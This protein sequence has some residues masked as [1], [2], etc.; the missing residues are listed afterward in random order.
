MGS[1]STRSSRR[2]ASAAT[3]ATFWRLPFE[4]VRVFF[5]GS[6]SNRSSSSSRR[7]GS[8]PPPRRPSRS[9]T[10]PP[11]RLGHRPTSPGTYASRRC[12]S[13]ASAHGSPPKRPT[14]PDVARSRPSSTRM[15][16]DLPEPLGPR[17]PCTS[18]RSTVRSRPSSAR[19]DP[20]V[21][22]SPSIEITRPAMTPRSSAQSSIGLRS[23]IGHQSSTVPSIASRTRSA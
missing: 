13:T 21:L 4:Y 23:S 12:N 22:T 9:I 16:V 8:W 17:N 3:S 11:D 6:S 1:S 5:V 18:P 19:N 10:S 14:D 2:P 20:K 7:C 15:V